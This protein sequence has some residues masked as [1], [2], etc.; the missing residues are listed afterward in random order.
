MIV[1]FEN[2]YT[3]ELIYHYDVSY[4]VPDESCFGVTGYGLHFT[5][6]TYCLVSSATY[7][8]VYASIQ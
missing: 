1:T 5:D 6:N 2:R 8:F 7:K 3:E 4:F